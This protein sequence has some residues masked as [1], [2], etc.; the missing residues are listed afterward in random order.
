MPK[1]SL[2]QLNWRDR[3]LTLESSSTV[4]SSLVTGK[5]HVSIENVTLLLVPLHNN[6]YHEADPSQHCL[7]EKATSGLIQPR[8]L[9][10]FSTLRLSSFTVRSQ[11]PASALDDL[12]ATDL[13]STSHVD[14]DYSKTSSYLDLS[15]LYG[16]N[17]EE[18]DLVRTFVDG[19]MKPD[20]FSTYR[21]LG[22]PPGVPALLICFNRFHNYIAGELATINDGGRFDVPD[23]PDI[24]LLSDQDA[25]LAKAKFDRLTVKRDNDLFQVSRLITCGLYVNIVLIDYV[26]VILNLNR[27][28]SAWA[29]NPRG[30]Y[31][32]IGDMADTPT[33]IGN[34]VS[35]EFNL[36]YRWHCSMSPKDEKW[37]EGFMAKLF[38][39]KDPNTLTPEELIAGS[40]KWGHALDPDPSKWEFN[41]LKRAASG[42][43]D[44]A[45]LNK[46]ITEST[47]DLAGKLSFHQPKVSI[48]C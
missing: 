16:N 41:G 15:P 4:S 42:A 48:M 36:I 20:T 22:F 30:I 40:M 11:S 33:A 37:M 10:C 14:A 39:G 13:F 27:T 3:S 9:A 28:D 34:Q 7:T 25:K 8:F 35:V 24:H 43:F 44:D 45:E 31:D 23:V 26:R 29:L 12:F 6:G 32:T 21:V 2:H 5:I 38:P 1:V 47:E 19:K 46:I 17:Q 18:Q